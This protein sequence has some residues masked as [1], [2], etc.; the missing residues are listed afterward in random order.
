MFPDNPEYTLGRLFAGQIGKK[1]RYGGEAAF[2]ILNF[3]VKRIVQI[4]NNS[5]YH[6]QFL[7]LSTIFGQIISI[8]DI[9]ILAD[10]V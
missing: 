5:S 10:N 8:K 9:D 4:K 7:L 6:R 3:I 1:F 2:T